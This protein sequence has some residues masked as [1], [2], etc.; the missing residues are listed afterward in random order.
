MSIQMRL[1]FATL[2]CQM[3]ILLLVI[4]PLPHVV[5]VK[6]IDLYNTL[7]K[8]PNFRIGILFMTILLGMQFFDCLNKLNRFTYM[9]KPYYVQNQL[10]PT[11]LTSE[12]MASKFYTQRNLYLTGAVLYL[13]ISIYT[14][15]TIL[16]KLVKKESEYRVL[17]A[18]EPIVA[19]DKDEIEK[20]N[21]LID[22]KEKDIEVFRKQLKNLQSSYDSLNKDEG[23]NNKKDD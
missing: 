2:T 1:I 13:E 6:V 5:R 4:L 14:V 20:Y 15:F 8:N 16:M 18:Q 17:K 7:R 19:D 21:V 3:T 10:P 9:D 22:K 23:I 12:Q 11:Q